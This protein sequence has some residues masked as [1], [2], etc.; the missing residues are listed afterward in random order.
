MAVTR[1]HLLT[2]PFDVLPEEDIEQTVLDLLSKDTPQHILFFTVWDLLKA[3]RNAEFRAMAENAALCL[4]LSKSLLSAARFLKLPVPIRRDSFNM[5]IRIL[6]AI[7]AHYKSVYLLGG[8]LQHLADAERNVRITFPNAQIVGR[9]HGYYHKSLEQD[10]LLSITKAHPAV[11]IAGNGLPGGIRW[12]YRNR[13]QLPAS[14]FVHCNDII[15]IFAKRKRR[16]SDSAF[17]RGHEFLP[18]LLK[19][20][21]KIFYLFRYINFLLTVLFYKL[22]R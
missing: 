8:H 12:I 15:D 20:P 3:R 2:I 9:F 1:I 5:V 18:Q 22:F 14:I 21:L 6:A 13:T 7:D 11:V 10:I 4:P 17:K 16:I 19:N